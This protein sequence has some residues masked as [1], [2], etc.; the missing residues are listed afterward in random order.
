M[1]TV[2]Y[3]VRC[4]DMSDRPTGRQWGGIAMIASGV[5]TAPSTAFVSD[6]SSSISIGVSAIL[7]LA[8]GASL[9]PRMEGAKPRWLRV[10]WII[11]LAAITGLFGYG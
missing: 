8:L 2:P 10:L 5:L 1:R 3:H 11:A 7:L 9:L 4:K 6:P